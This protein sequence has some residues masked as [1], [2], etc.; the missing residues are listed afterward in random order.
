MWQL[1]LTRARATAFA[2]VVIATLGLV[3]APGHGQGASLIFDS[4]FEG[5]IWQQLPKFGHPLV[6]FRFQHLP[7]YSG[8]L[9]DR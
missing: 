7:A 8:V 1:H 4:T 3:T 5:E 6:V 2:V 9:T